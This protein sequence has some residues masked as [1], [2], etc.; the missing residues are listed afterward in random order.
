VYQFT[1]TAVKIKTDRFS[2]LVWGCPN[3]DD[4]ETLESTIVT[5]ETFNYNNIDDALSI[6]HRQLHEP[7]L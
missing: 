4:E 6:L 1:T 7:C 2:K 3:T 5:E